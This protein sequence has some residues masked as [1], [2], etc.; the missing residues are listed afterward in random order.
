[1][2]Q[3]KVYTTCFTKGVK[4]FHRVIYS[5]GEND[6]Q[7]ADYLMFYAFIKNIYVNSIHED[8][9]HREAFP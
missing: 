1:M 6:D 3:T 4:G 2:H 9:L 5:E 7:I 8:S